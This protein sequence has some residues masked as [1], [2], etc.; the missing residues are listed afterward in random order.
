MSINKAMR[1]LTAMIL[2]VVMVAGMAP[3]LAAAETG[4]LSI[5]AGGEITAL[6]QLASEIAVQNVSV[7]TFVSDLRLPATLTATVRLI[8]GKPSLSSPA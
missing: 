4:A 7:G 6:E 3:I 2:S 8:A 1:T 5:G